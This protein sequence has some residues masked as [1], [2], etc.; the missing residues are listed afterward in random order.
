MVWLRVAAVKRESSLYPAGFGYILEG[1]T[2]ILADSLGMEYEKK[3]G[4]FSSLTE[5]RE[6][7][8]EWWRTCCGLRKEDKIK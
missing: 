7:K 6:Y 3:M 5:G 8:C 4:V 2:D 1:R